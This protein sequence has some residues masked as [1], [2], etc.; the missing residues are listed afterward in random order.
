MAYIDERT[1][2]HTG[3]ER[4]VAGPRKLAP[5]RDQMTSGQEHREV[6]AGRSSPSPFTQSGVLA[7]GMMLPTFLWVLTLQPSL[8]TASDMPKSDLLD[9]SRS[10]R[11]DEFDHHS[12]T[13]YERPAN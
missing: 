6:D 11:V 12:Q 5:H 3:K 13:C 7:H 1:V 8:E 4:W 10:C 2:G 9:D